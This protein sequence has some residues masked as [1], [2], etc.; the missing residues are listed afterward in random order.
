MGE[1][2]ENVP[3]EDVLSLSKTPP[4][5]YERVCH[6]RSC[7]ALVNANK[8]GTQGKI[9]ATDEVPFRHQCLSNH[10]FALCRKLP[11]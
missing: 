5:L 1:T 10:N 9:A 3:K 7:T 11:E 4:S 8:F 6:V 2:L